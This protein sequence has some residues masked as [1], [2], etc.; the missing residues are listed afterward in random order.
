ML[1]MV[2]QVVQQIDKQ[3]MKQIVKYMEMQYMKHLVT[4]TVV[5]AV[6]TRIT[7]PFRT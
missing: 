1:E 6:G 3:T 2:K 5:Q 4:G 7:L